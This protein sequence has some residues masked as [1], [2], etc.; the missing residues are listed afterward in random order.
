M[1]ENSYKKNLAHI[2]YYMSL[3]LK[4]IAELRNRQV[5][6][7]RIPRTKVHAFIFGKCSLFEA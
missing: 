5:K 7:E 2:K 6:K 3:T 4:K 1:S